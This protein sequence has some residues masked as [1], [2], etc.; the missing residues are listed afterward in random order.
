MR[1]ISEGREND[2]KRYMEYVNKI[3]EITLKKL[4]ECTSD[5]TKNS[6]KL[7]DEKEE[8]IKK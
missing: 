6:E 5:L 2:S 7:T 4:E 8:Q 1:A 3:R